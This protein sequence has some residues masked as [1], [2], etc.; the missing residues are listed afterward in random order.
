MNT[1]SFLVRKA[2]FLLLALGFLTIFSLQTLVPSLA[3]N[4][5]E[6]RLEDK[7]PK[8]V[9]IKVK[10]KS[11][12][13]KSFRDL[14]NTKWVR[15][16]ELEV[17]NTSDKPI[18]FLELWLIFP[19]LIEPNGGPNGIPLRFGRMAFVDFK[20][21]PTNE[22]VSID[23]GESYVY[24]IPDKYQRGWYRHKAKAGLSDPKKVVLQFIQL[25]FGDGSGFNGT[26]AKPYPYKKDLRSACREG[27]PQPPFTLSRTD[28]R[29]SFRSSATDSVF[30]ALAWLERQKTSGIIDFTPRAGVSPRYSKKLL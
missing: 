18:Y 16:F 6:R 4:S 11:E 15:D 19:E 2:L 27:P 26:D 28:T 30:Q 29:N 17:T 7:I 12:K 25:S 10:I 24:E 1:H 9:P 5:E 22:D 8:H 20:T 23:P 13:E 3:Q 21:R 14:A